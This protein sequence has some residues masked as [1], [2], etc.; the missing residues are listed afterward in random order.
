MLFRSDL[1]V[2]LAVEAVEHRTQEVGSASAPATLRDATD[3]LSSL[4]AAR[5]EVEQSDAAWRGEVPGPMTPGR[6]RPAPPGR[7]RGTPPAAKDPQ[8]ARDARDARH[9]RDTRHGRERGADDRGERDERGEDDGRG[10][11]MPG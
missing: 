1:L 6:A 8:S 9:A 3:R 10:T 11:P 4:R 2:A 7:G 5:R